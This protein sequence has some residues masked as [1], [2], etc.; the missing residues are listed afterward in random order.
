MDINEYVKSEVERQHSDRFSE[1]ERAFYWAGMCDPQT[2]LQHSALLS[3]LDG[4]ARRVEPD[5]NPMWEGHSWRRSEVGFLHGGDAAAAIDIPARMRR[6]ASNF[7]FEA[8]DYHPGDGL[9]RYIEGDTALADMWVKDLLD[10][11]PW[12]D[13][14]GRVASIFRNWLLDTMRNPLPLPYYFGSE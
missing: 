6:W 2:V 12:A 5:M 8:N 7:I 11:H 14:N 10:I 9:R 13:G 1:F 3:V 4:I